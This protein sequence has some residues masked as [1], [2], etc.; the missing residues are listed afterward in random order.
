MRW[1]H[2][3]RLHISAG[4]WMW[5]CGNRSSTTGILFCCNDNYALC[6]THIKKKIDLQ[7]GICKP[8]VYRNRERIKRAFSH[9]A[10][11]ILVLSYLP[12]WAKPKFLSCSGKSSPPDASE[13]SDGLQLGGTLWSSSFY[14]HLWHHLSFC[15]LFTLQALVILRLSQGHSRYFLFV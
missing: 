9:V 3:S 11:K 12:L 5:M 14:V 4:I 1:S 6:V 13:S 2:D 10:T 7:L 15:S 8:H